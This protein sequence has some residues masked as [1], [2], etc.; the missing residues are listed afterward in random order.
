[1]KKCISTTA[2]ECLF[3][4]PSRH[5]KY[6]KDNLDHVKI[7]QTKHMAYLYGENNCKFWYVEK[8]SELKV[9]PKPENKLS[10]YEAIKNSLLIDI[11]KLLPM[12]IQQSMME[13]RKISSEGLKQQL[14]AHIPVINEKIVK[15]INKLKSD[16]KDICS[17]ISGIDDD[18]LQAIS[19]KVSKSMQAETVIIDEKFIELKDSVE[20]SSLTLKEEHDKNIVS[21]EKNLKE[22]FN[23][24]SNEASKIVNSNKELKQQLSTVTQTLKDFI[25]LQHNTN[26]NQI[27]INEKLEKIYQQ[28]T[29]DVEETKSKLEELEDRVNEVE[30]YKVD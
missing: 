9:T 25:K 13:F 10:A 18:I 11:T 8:P 5:C 30:I 26:E 16:Y 19:H 4:T 6:N 7:M 22:F 2:K 3:R 17:K 20:L 14:N 21:M 15:E 27:K 28:I 12:V 23:S 29:D 1:M 24:V